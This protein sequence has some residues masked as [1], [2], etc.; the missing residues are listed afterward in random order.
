MT[1]RHWSEHEFLALHLEM[2][3]IRPSIVCDSTIILPWAS[4]NKVAHGHGYHITLKGVLVGANLERDLHGV[5][6]SKNSGVVEPLD[7]VGVRM[8]RLDQMKLVA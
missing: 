1:W 5:L 2:I 4:K 3:V 6:D 7:L 8:L